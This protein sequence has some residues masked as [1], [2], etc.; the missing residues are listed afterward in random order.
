[1]LDYTAGLDKKKLTSI[2]N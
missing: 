2:Q 1:M